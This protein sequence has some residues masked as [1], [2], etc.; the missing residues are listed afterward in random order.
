MTRWPRGAAAFAILASG[1]FGRPASADDAPVPPL[2]KQLNNG[3]WLP[4]AE[5]EQP[6]QAEA[7]AER[8]AAPAMRRH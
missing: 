7:A 6:A 2:V 5:A 1:M 8:V 3:N 4:Q